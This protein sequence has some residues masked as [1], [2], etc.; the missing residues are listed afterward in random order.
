MHQSDSD[1]TWARGT[2]TPERQE[3]R[4]EWKAT[5]QFRAYLRYASERQVD[6]QGQARRVVPLEIWYVGPLQRH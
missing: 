2:E 5:T 6:L 4:W 3:W 1:L